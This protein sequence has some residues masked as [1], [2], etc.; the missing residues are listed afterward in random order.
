MQPDTAPSKAGDVAM[1]SLRRR[2]APRVIENLVARY[3]A[4][5]DTPALSRA[6]GISKT[7]L[8]QLFQAEGVSLRRRAMTPADVERAVQLYERGL[9]ISEVVR[10]VG[11]SS[12]TVQ[13]AL[14]KHGVTMRAS[15][16]RKLRMSNGS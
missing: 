6:Y 1:R 4:G 8:L 12:S 11:Y 16:V 14:H 10:Q 7:G 2:L 5:E 3:N 9:M 15:C 13:R